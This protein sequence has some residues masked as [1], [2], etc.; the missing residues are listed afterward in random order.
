MPQGDKQLRKMP[1]LLLRRGISFCKVLSC[2]SVMTLLCS[3]NLR[4][5]TPKSPAIRIFIMSVGMNTRTQT[6]KDVIKSFDVYMLK[7]ISPQR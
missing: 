5:F 7:Y 4:T 6:V 2:Y 3:N 1:F